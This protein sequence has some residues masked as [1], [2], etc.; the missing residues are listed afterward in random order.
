MKE[1]NVINGECSKCGRCCSD[2]LPLTSAEIRYMKKKAK[3]IKPTFREMTCPFLSLDNSCLIYNNRPYIC[4]TYRCDKKPG[5][6]EAKF[7]LDNDVRTV[8]VS[9]EIFGVKL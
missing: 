8:V 3:N 9:R 5:I 7:Y 1:V 6:K 2:I 4:R